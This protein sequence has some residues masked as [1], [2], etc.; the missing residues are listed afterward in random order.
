MVRCINL[1]S[2]VGDIDK[3][4]TT[5]A[6]LQDSSSRAVIDG[7]FQDIMAVVVELGLQSSLWKKP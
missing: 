1:A 7:I 4:T 3:D 5:A 6:G 2:F